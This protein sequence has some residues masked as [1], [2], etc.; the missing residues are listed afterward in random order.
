MAET[1]SA[2]RSVALAEARGRLAAGLVRDG[3]REAVLA[4]YDR[5]GADLW[6]GLAAVY[7]AAQVLP[8]VVDV[9]LSV[10]AARPP[11]LRLRDTERT[12]RP[13]WFQDATTIGYV[14]YADLFG[15]T[16]D[17]IRSRIDYLT[18][19]GIT[20]LHLM[21]L[22]TPRPGANDGGYAVMDYRSVRSDLG[23]MDDLAAL[24]DGLH[25]A[26]ISLT[27][28]LVLNHVAREHQWAARARAG[29]P[30]YHDYFYVFP[31]REVPDAYE[32]TLPEV[33]PAFAPGNFTFDAD[34]DGWVWTTFNEWQWDLNWANPDVFLEFA[35]TIGFLGN[36]GA[37]CIRLDAIAFV[38][39]RMG[40][41][42]QNQ[43][44]VHA[45]TQALRAC[46]RIMA[47]AVIFKAEAIV[48]RQDVVGYL[49]QGEHAG[50]VSDLAY[51]NSLMVQI[52]SALAARDGR[53]LA[54]AL[55]A[56]APVP[57]TTAWATYLRCHDDIGWAIDDSDAAMVGWDGYG[58]R[59]FLADFYAGDFPGSFARGMHF[60][61]NPETG[62]RRTSGSAASLAGLQ[63]ATERHDAAALAL[64]E[65]RLACAY[66]M[67]FGFGGLP[68]LYMGD[69]L[70]MVND[71][72]YLAD[73]AKSADNRW[74]HRPVMDWTV[75]DAGET[76]AGSAGRIFARVRRL[77]SARRG[78]PALHASVTT[79]AL[80]ASNPA[81]L[82]FRRRHAAGSIV[83]AYNLSEHPQTFDAAALWPLVSGALVERITGTPVAWTPEVVLPP[84]AA[85]WLTSPD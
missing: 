65:D 83:Q 30:R 20:Y 25:D 31:D 48:G 46:A 28:D 37:D 36:Q 69:E 80:V 77:I 71:P 40:T 13:D 14:A 8:R 12:L 50:K 61:A 73:P 57:V 38:W 15:G 54:T 42:C 58:H 62:D 68:L 5:W 47:P 16:L 29:E 32:A 2:A 70:A 79:E 72:D 78:L 9:I 51:H 81:V 24:A 10:H 67:V 1:T 76:A 27:L 34:L 59:S 75:A 33:F 23:T 82:V 63:A 26:G 21:P 4:R 53:L 35:D 64:A 41:N 22:L 84:Y 11:R 19:L 43:P 60:Q 56:F 18:G 55:S 17:G 39:K 3:D 45:I 52:W 74:V 66:A 6:D 44:E 49:G 7:D 85:W